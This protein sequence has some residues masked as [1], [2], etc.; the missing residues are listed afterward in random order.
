MVSIIRSKMVWILAA[1]S[2]A[3]VGCE[4]AVE[5]VDFT[6]PNALV[7]DVRTL[8]E[9]NGAHLE[10]A[11]RIDW[12]NIRQGVASIGVK[13]DQPIYIYCQSGNRAGKAEKMLLDQ[14]Y[15][16]VYNMGGLQDA[17]RLTGVR[18]VR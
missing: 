9:W 10:T 13:K 1:L 17:I 6:N 8:D 2:F 11:V 15:T 16:N 7:I 4:P 5:A 12:Q 18:A 3:L 14:G